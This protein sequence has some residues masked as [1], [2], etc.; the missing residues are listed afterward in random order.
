MLYAQGVFINFNAVTD[1]PLNSA[2]RNYQP[3]ELPAAEFFYVA[4]V[5]SAYPVLRVCALIR[6][7]I[8]VTAHHA[9][10]AA[11]AVQTRSY[12]FARPVRPVI[13]PPC[14]YAAAIW[15]NH[16]AF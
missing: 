7:C 12:Q 3:H 4:P 13:S 1:R 9:S 11:A 15:C 5:L 2:S 14:F 6:G 8:P 16:P 10:I